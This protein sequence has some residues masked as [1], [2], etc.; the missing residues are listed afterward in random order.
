MLEWVINIEQ[1]VERELVGE[2]QPA[3]VS[4]CLQQIPQ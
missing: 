3:P 1:M 2:A 4:L